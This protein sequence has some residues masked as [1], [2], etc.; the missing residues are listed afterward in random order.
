MPHFPKPFFRPKKDRWYVQL[1][2]KHVNLGTDRDSAFERYHALMAQR[3]KARPAPAAP[4]ASPHPLVITVLDEFLIWL[5]KRVEEGTKAQRTYDWY[6][7]YLNSFGSFAADD[8]RVRDLTADALEPIHVY[9][10]V[11]AQPG[12]KT[13]RRGAMVAVQRAFNWAA[14]A[15]LLK[16]LGGKSPLAALEKPQQGRRDQLVSPEEF[17][18]V[19]ALVRDQEFQDLL[20]LSWE[21][22]ARP[23]ELFT[24][25][26][27]YVDLQNGRWVFPVRESKGKKVQRVV[28][29]TDRAMEITRRLTLKHPDGPM[30]RNTD[31]VPWCMS[32]V[33]RRFQRVRDKLGVK[34]S[35]YAFRHSFCTFALAAGKLDA[36]TVSVLMG[37]RD[38]TMIS[39]HYAHLTQRADYLRDAARRAKGA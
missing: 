7:Q 26:A 25:E 6:E 13:G 4:L 38:T 30:L 10:W 32:S 29:L 12:W 20:W 9:R 11:D 35:L 23:H 3:A 2:G 31:G 17:Q 14:K 8:F 37:H 34:Y 27:G 33:N 16:S 18:R 22:G 1:N 28:Y 21:T 15:G 24:A 36:V 19:L 5:A 39:R